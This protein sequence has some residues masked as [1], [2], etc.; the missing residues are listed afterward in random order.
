MVRLRASYCDCGHSDAYNRGMKVY[1]LGYRTKTDEEVE[2]ERRTLPRYREIEDTIV[3]FGDAPNP[4]WPMRAISA[5]RMHRDRLQGYQ[6]HVDDHFCSFTVE[7]IPE[8]G[9][10]IVCLTHPP[11]TGVPGPFCTRR[12]ETNWFKKER[13]WHEGR[14]THLS[15]W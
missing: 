1:V 10:A 15:R 3:S 9:F 14:S 4:K 12:N 11:L 8:S 5:A 7:E 2:A 6:I 13:R